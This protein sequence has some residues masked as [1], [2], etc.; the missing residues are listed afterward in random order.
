M[1]CS[2][3]HRAGRFSLFCVG[4]RSLLGAPASAGVRR[5]CRARSSRDGAPR[6]LPRWLLPRAVAAPR[7]R[8]GWPRQPAGAPVL[9][10]PH[11]GWSQNVDRPAPLGMF[12]LDERQPRAEMVS[13]AT[14]SCVPFF[15]MCFY[16]G[17]ICGR[18]AALVAWEPAS[19]LARRFLLWLRG[20][21]REWRGTSSLR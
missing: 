20:G 6:L 16:Q 11:H 19:L 7:Q 3:W 10:I 1:T 17:L 8:S 12:V 2:P 14:H 5:K 13:C 21:G 18:I 15:N 4:Q 9:L